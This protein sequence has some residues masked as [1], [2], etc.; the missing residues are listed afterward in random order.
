MRKL[1]AALIILLGLAHAALA[2]QTQPQGA[3]AIICAYNSAPSSIT[4]GFFGY[5]Q[6][7]STG[8]LITSGGG[9]GAI[10][11]A[12]G[13]LATIGSKAD[14]AWD[15]VAASPSL[16]AI[17][18]YTA[19]VPIPNVTATLSG[20]SANNAATQIALQGTNSASV[21]LSG[22]WVG[23]LTPQVSSDSGT[24]WAATVFFNPA[25]QAITT[26]VTAS[27]TYDILGTGG[28]TH[29]RV[30]LSPYTS[31]TV[32]GNLSATSQGPSDAA[33]LYGLALQT[34]TAGV[35]APAAVTVQGFLTG[36]TPVPTIP[37]APVNNTYIGN[38]N[39]E[40]T[41][42]TYSFGVAGL[43]PTAAATDIACITGSGTKTIRITRI[44]VAGIATA[45]SAADVLLLRRSTANSG[46]TSSAP[47]LVPNDVNNA[48]ATATALTYTANPTT[49]TLVGNV[50]A[51]KT[52]LSTGAGAIPI[53]PSI[54]DFTTN[55]SQ[56]EVLRG[57]TQ[58][59][60]VNWNGQTITGNSLDLDAQFTEE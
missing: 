54:W 6:C 39:T 9:G 26:T 53:V 8:K 59:L 45:A 46:G 14:A 43:V 56:G 42:A 51:Q 49:G 34:G 31:G 29:A 35:P 7:D 21:L 32:T 41:K 28:K 22:T 60:C 4:S 30:L 44:S 25:T 52:T 40:G 36:G 16:I 19:T 12:D 50:R 17:A 20:M 15:G 10:T 57:T 27:G 1:S 48:A 37:T 11:A 5:V 33:V 2:Q 13:A 23:T 3:S 24:T 55:N 38:V 58:S 18:K 47:A